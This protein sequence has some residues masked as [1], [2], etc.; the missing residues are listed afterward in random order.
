MSAN[1]HGNA[2]VKASVKRMHRPSRMEAVERGRM[3]IYMF[4]ARLGF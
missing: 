4:L 2:P 3:K 1:K